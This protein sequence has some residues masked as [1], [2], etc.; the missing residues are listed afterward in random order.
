M[1]KKK[2]KEL[3]IYLTLGV[4]L[5]AA[6]VVGFVLINGQDINPDT[7]LAPNQSTDEASGNSE[8]VPDTEGITIDKNAVTEEAHFYPY[9][10]N[11]TYMEVIAIR[12]ED[13]TVRTAFNTCQI[14]FDS[15]RGY[16][17]QDGEVLV[18]QNCGNRFTVDQ[19]EVV[20]GG[21]NPVPIFKDDKTET[22]GVI[23]ISDNV[24]AE[25]S[26]LFSKWKR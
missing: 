9:Q 5:A 3:S 17:K 2:I 14:C 22:D 7:A 26:M 21:C 25:Y 8:A 23:T 11:D 4:I 12:A 15:G 10:S 6:G 13:G 19:I 1:T 24:L 20:N 18:C 16:Y